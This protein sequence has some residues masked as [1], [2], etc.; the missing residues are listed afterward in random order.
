MQNIRNLISKT[1]QIFLIFVFLLSSTF[2]SFGNEIEANNGTHIS[3]RKLIKGTW[4]VAGTFS[5]KS[6]DYNHIDLLVADID[7]YYQKAYTI[8]LEGAYFFKENMSSGLGLYYGGEDNKLTVGIL[9]NSFNREL[10]SIGKKYGTLAFLKNHIPVS[11]NNIFFITNQTEVYYD[12]ESGNSQTNAGSSLERK[13]S[14]KHSFG[15]GIR[16]GILIFFTSGFAFDINMGILGFSHTV[17]GHK[18]E[19]SINQ[20]HSKLLKAI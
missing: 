14:V 2:I 13:N 12:Y 18:N 8:R 4:S 10:Q 15:L 16:P 6:K 3:G 1:L 19:K 9:D 7:K 17:Q 5:G 11:N 20:S